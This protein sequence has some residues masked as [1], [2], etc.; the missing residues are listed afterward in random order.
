ME[1]EKKSIF[2]RE[3]FQKKTH[4]EQKPQTAQQA[5]DWA[6]HMKGKEEHMEAAC[7]VKFKDASVWH[8]QILTRVVLPLTVQAERRHAGGTVQDG[9]AAG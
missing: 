2:K 3:S 4:K 6:G 9:V 7:P 8:K 1:C 5:V